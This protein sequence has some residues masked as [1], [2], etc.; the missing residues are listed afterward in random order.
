MA[1]LVDKGCEQV[2]L[3]RHWIYESDCSLRFA[4]WVHNEANNLRY[5]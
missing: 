2:L 4:T 3:E 5:A 1:L